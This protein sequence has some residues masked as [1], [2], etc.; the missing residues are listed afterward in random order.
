M[1]LEITHNYMSSKIRQS[2]FIYKGLERIDVENHIEWHEKNQLLKVM[3]PLNINNDKVRYDIQFGSLESDPH[4]N[5]PFECAK[6]EHVA[7][8]FVDISEKD[9]GF[10]LLND[11]KYGHGIVDNVLSLTMLKSGSFPFD[12]ASEI[13]P[14]F[15]Y[16]FV[17]HKGN[18]KDSKVNE[19]SYVLNNPLKAIEIKN[20]SGMLPSEFSFVK[21]L[22][23]GVI[24]ETIKKAEDG[25]SIVIRL[26]E[27]YKENKNVTLEFGFDVK[28]ALVLDLLENKE[29]CLSVK[30]NR[31]T[32]EIKPF[33]IITLGV[34]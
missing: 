4:S 18:F 7:H 13:I 16:S 5:D 30:D 3:F 29:N 14:D 11:C 32:F 33:E 23:P 28:E 34:K 6:F 20:D 27:A 24:I 26:Y 1:G 15:V 19:L 25:N 22:T 9:Y 10:A 2:F 8:K 21:C 17:P 31:V 12:G